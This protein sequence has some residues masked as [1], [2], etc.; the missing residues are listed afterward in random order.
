MRRCPITNEIIEPHKQYS[1]KG[2]SLLSPLLSNLQPLLLTA[3][4]Q[5]SEAIARAGKMSIQGVQPKLSAILNKKEERFEIVDSKG[6][7]ILKTPS[8][9]YPEVPENE[10]LTMSL[11]ATIGLEVPIH[12]LIYSIDSSMTYFVKR[13]DRLPRGKKLAVEDFAQLSGLSRDTKYESSMENIINIIMRYCTY[14]K[15]ECMKLFKLVVFNFLVGNEDMHLKN[16]SLITRQNKTTLSPAYD[17]LNTTIALGSPVEEIALPLKGR[18]NHLT[19]QNLFDY[20][21]KE[22]LGLNQKIIDDVVNEIREKLPL[23]KDM[24]KQSF[25]SEKMQK[26]YLALLNDRQQRLGL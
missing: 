3:Q 24:I 11:A 1:K 5:R 7:Y 15:I 4:E 16:Y 8:A 2:L 25:L 23:W 21:A 10:A 17:L 14:P 6:T 26:K 19:R 9:L 12:G 20:F 22:R 18:K 13:F